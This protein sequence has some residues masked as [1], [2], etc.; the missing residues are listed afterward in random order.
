MQI[1][2]S[3][4]NKF[5]DCPYQYKLSYI[6]KCQGIYYSMDAMDIG[7]YVHKALENFYKH[8]YTVDM[9]DAEEILYY[10]YN[11]LK[12]LWDTTLSVEDFEKAH[13]CLSNHAQ[14][15][16]SY[17][18]LSEPFSEPHIVEKTDDKY[19]WHGY[20]DFIDMQNLKVIDWKTN[21]R[22]ALSKQYRIQAEIYKILF[23][24]KYDIKLSHF[25]FYFLYPDE[26]RTVAFHKQSQKKIISLLEQQKEQFITSIENQEFP[27]KPRTPKM[28]KW[29]PYR[30]YCK[31]LEQ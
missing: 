12:Q 3:A 4:L 24:S 22:A 19:K 21:K 6:D 23:E 9:K 20:I 17:N 2:Q 27:K 31:V 7:G 11:N 25:H 28:C 14:W 1:S 30:F 16:A 26:W 5:I 15:Q 29:C 8:T 10:T 13:T 18:L